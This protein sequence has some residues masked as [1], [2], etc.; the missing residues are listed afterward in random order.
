MRSSNTEIL[1]SCSP[2]AA[3]MPPASCAPSARASNAPAAPAR[4][5]DWRAAFAGLAA[6]CALGA[7]AQDKACSKADEAAAAKAVDRIVM[8]SQ[9]QG[10]WKDYRH[11][12]TGAIDDAFTDAVMRM[13][14]EWKKPQALA[15]AMAQDPAYAAFIVKHL[16]SPAAK[17]DRESV[18]SRAKSDCPADLGAFCEKIAEASKP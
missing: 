17:E 7:A 5:R 8:W 6:A 9:L 16:K 4:R 12:D 1:S 10:T 14:V 3:S 13:L 18:Y 15:E 11:C 2:I